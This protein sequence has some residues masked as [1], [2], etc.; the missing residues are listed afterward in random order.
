MTAPAGRPDAGDFRSLALISTAVTGMVA[1][2]LIGVWLDNR[3][4]WA[5]WGMAAGAVVGV[6]GGFA[7][8][9]MMSR[10]ANESDGPP[11]T[12]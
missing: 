9:V 4:G 2:I 7:R 11:T 10:R 8:L 6:G 1:P 5:P 12:G 3:Y